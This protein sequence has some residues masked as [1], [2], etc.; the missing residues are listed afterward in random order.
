M[1]TMSPNNEYLHDPIIPPVKLSDSWAGRRLVEA[2]SQLPPADFNSSFDMRFQQK[3]QQEREHRRLEMTDEGASSTDEIRSPKHITNGKVRQMFDERRRGAGIDRANPLKPISSTSKAPAPIPRQVGGAIHNSNQTRNGNIASVKPRG[4]AN[5]NS[6]STNVRNPPRRLLNGNADALSKEMSSLSLGLHS[7]DDRNNNRDNEVL[8]RAKSSNSLK[9]NPVVTKKSPSP[10][11]LPAA[12]IS[13]RPVNTSATAAAA[14]RT[15]VPKQSSTLRTSKPTAATTTKT[16]PRSTSGNMATTAGNRTQAD[17][18]A[19]NSGLC[20]YCNRHFNMERLPKHEKICEKMAHTKRKTFDAARHR[21]RGTDA[22]KY[23]K[24]AQSRNN[25]NNKS[26]YSS[27][28]AV[29]GMSGSMKKNNWRKK[30][31][32]FIQ[33]IRAAKQVQA[34]LARGG[35]LSDLPPPPP[36]ENPDYIQCPHCLRRFNESAAERHIP[37]CA[38][39][40]HN[41]PK[42]GKTAPRRR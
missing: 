22:E 40:L 39:M 30:H 6:V 16:P 11:P 31:E 38:T 32:E 7:P 15:P 19:G 14:R 21:L 9:L 12:P 18:D 1:T 23:V 17:I 37:R 4:V 28:A 10:V 33:A 27:A 2:L 34:H 26:G 24:K 5:A 25:A 8:G 29:S 3:Q 41:K 13:K 20:C 36:S 35:K 42:P